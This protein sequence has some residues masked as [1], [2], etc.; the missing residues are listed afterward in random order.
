ML[1]VTTGIHSNLRQLEIEVPSQEV[2][3]RFASRAKEEKEEHV[4]DVRAFF[5]RPRRLECPC[6]DNEDG[7]PWPWTKLGIDSS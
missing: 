3:G 5:T 7:A 4:V 1:A 2:L 6:L